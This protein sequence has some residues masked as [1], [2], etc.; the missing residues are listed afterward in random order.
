MGP[1]TFNFAQAAQLALAAGAAQR[2][3]DLDAGV[4]AALALLGSAR[5]ADM[6][7]AAVAFASAHRGAAE[8]M[9]DQIVALLGQR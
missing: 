6:A 8:R 1:H 2:V 5:L 3:D 4:A 9:A 7:R